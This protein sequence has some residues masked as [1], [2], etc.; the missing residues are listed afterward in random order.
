M[1]FAFSPSPARGLALDRA[2]RSRFADSLDAISSTLAGELGADSASLRQLTTAIRAHPVRPAV[3][4]LYAELVPAFSGDDTRAGELLA[5]LAAP[6]WCEPADMRVITVNNADLGP[7]LAECYRRHLNDDPAMPLHVSALDSEALSTGQQLMSSAQALLEE[8]FPALAGEIAAIV[9]E[10]L[11][12]RPGDTPGAAVFH[13][14]SN[15]Y[16]WGSLVL[17]LN[18]HPTR[19]KMVEGLA[20]ESDHSI[21]Y[22]LTMGAPMVRND[23]IER[24]NSPLRDDPRP[25]DGIVHATYVLARMHLALTTILPSDDLTEAERGE[26]ASRIAAITRDYAE[27]LAV[28][29]ASAQFTEQGAAAFKGAECYMLEA[30]GIGHP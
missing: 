17:N 20:H 23:G 8:A 21:L 19:I 10:V 24:Y 25:I 16:L 28:V 22:G 6:H 11:L 29:A 27:G 4:A 1:E 2:V 13:G 9:N 26:A 5:A 15:F 14:A 12:V 18:A 3:M 30:T 7:G